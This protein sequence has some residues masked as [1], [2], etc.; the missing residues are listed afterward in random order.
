MDRAL[1]GNLNLKI[2]WAR[3]NQ[4]QAQA[5]ISGAGIFPSLEGQAGLSRS[6]LHESGRTDE[7]GSYRLALL[8]SYEVDLW[9]RIRS[10]RDAALLDATAGQQELQAAA[11][12]LS[13]QVATTWYQ[14]IEQNGQARILEQQ[15]QTN[16]QL[17]ELIRLKVRTGQAGIADLLQQQQLIQTSRGELARLRSRAQVLGHQLAVLLGL[18]PDRPVAPG[19]D[20]LP[21]LPLLPET[22][23]PAELVQRRP[24]IRAAWA[25]LQA[26]DQRLSVA[27]AERFPRL[28]L[29]GQLGSEAENIGDLFDNW[30]ATL[31]G[32]LI[33]PIIDGGRR[34]AEMART[35]AVVAEELHSY[36]QIVLSALTEVEDALVRER[37]QL[38]YIEKLERQQL[39]AEQAIE[40]IRDRYINGGEDYQRVLTA[41]LSLQGVQRNRLTAQ[42]ELYEFRIQLC[43]ALAG[44]WELEPSAS[45]NRVGRRS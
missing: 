22:G 11:L 15:I 27:A 32:N 18:P 35:Q 33:G 19:V 40:R 24:D 2:A 13:A 26:A 20:S 28:S 21:A 43:R 25:R 29:S 44:S 17:L 9:G 6:W 5:R 31:A 23:L 36:G 12:T 30:L 45:L 16:T 34:R 1:T 41:Q 7:N 39:L 14:L 37:Q 42:R 38:L 3:L 10:Q 4:A 8:A